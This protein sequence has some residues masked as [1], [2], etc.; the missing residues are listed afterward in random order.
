MCVAPKVLPPLEKRVR[1]VQKKLRS[2][3]ELR[4]SIAS[5]KEPTPEQEAKLLAEAA[6]KVELQ[7]LQEQM[8]EQA[9][10][11]DA[12]PPDVIPPELLDEFPFVGR[13][14]GDDRDAVELA[15]HPQVRVHLDDAPWAGEKV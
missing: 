14:E 13:V 5:G 4:E 11:E 9:S 12:E 8:E 6:L 7:E 1:A 15:A 3:S 2:I 10:L